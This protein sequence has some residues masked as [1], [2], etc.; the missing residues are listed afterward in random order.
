MPKVKPTPMLDQYMA[1]KK[2]NPDCLLFYRL[3]DFYEIFG[4][5]AKEASVILGIT[6]TARTSG[7]GRTIKTPMCGI[8][9]HAAPAYVQKLLRAGRKVAMVE[10]MEDPK[11]TKGPV[12]R[13]VVRIITPGTTLDDSMLDAGSNNYVAAVFTSKAGIGLAAADNSTGEF[14]CTR[15]DKNHKQSF[16]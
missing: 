15:F 4:E 12:R 5:D 13:E 16:F 6:L 14:L 1:M 7:A 10:Q 11:K 3:G 9:H 2:Q 8:P